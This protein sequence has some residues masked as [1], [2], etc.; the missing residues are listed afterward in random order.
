MHAYPVGTLRHG[1]QL[2]GMANDSPR[3]VFA[4]ELPFPTSRPSFQRLF[5]DERACLDYMVRVRWPSGFVC[6]ICGVKETPL[7]ISTRLR[8]LRCSGCHRE[9]SATAGTVMHLS[10]SPLSVW[11][12]A[13]HLVSSMT[14][15]MSAV[16][17]QRQLGLGR[18]E[19]RVPDAP[20]A[21][22]RHGA[23]TSRSYRHPVP[24]RDGRNLDRRPHA[25]RRARMPPQNACCG[26]RRAAQAHQEDRGG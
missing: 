8:V 11:F 10:H 15:G 6:S 19:D 22:G 7:R 21:T 4:D 16:Q 2:V 5:P 18:Y 1:A 23:S 14:P 26:G 17:F 24:G 12:W 9:T 3:V 25:W 20:Q 13:A